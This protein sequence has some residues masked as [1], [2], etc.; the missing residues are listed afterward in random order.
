MNYVRNIGVGSNMNYYEA[1]RARKSIRKYDFTPLSQETLNCLEEYTKKAVPL[2]KEIGVEFKLLKA[3]EDGRDLQGKFRVKA[4]Y[5]LILS[6][7]LRQDYLL[8]AGYLMEQI[9]LYLTMHGIGTC[10][11]GALTPN[12]KLKKKLKYDYV[13][14]IAFGCPMEE[15]YRKEKHKNMLPEETTIICREECG[16]VTKEILQLALMSPSAMNIQPWRVVAYHNRLHIF[17]KKEW[18]Y[19]DVLGDIRLIDLGIFM[20]TLKLAAEELWVDAH[21]VWLPQIAAKKMK[22]NEYITSVMLEKNEF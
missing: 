8:N 22:R 21:F 9:V 6:S 10:Y 4:P 15:L 13:I 12:D 2:K 11:Q 16:A 1:I 19:K 17:S 20:A 18:F 3:W 5:Y 14:A 7:E